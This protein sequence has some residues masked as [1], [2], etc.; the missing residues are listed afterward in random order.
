MI[1]PAAARAAQKLCEEDLC[2][3]IADHHKTMQEKSLPPNH[4]KK[5]P[6]DMALLKAG[7]TKRFQCSE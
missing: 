7:E 5:Q 6:K 2:K 4:A 3:T 1:T